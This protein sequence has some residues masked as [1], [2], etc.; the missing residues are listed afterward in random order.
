M[1]PMKK[2]HIPVFFTIFMIAASLSIAVSVAS[3][4][5]ATSADSGKTAEQV[6]KNIQTLKGI[7]ADQLQPTMQF[8]SNSL[9]VECNFCHVQG[10]FDKDHKKPKLAARKM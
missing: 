6:F 5:N 10:A 3:A 1:I 4:Q 9:G 2:R 7:P 8:I